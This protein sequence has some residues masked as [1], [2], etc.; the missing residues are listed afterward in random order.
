MAS[1][2]NNIYE[3]NKNNLM[4]ENDDDDDHKNCE[5]EYQVKVNEK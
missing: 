2:K 1:N 5:V 4:E 3:G